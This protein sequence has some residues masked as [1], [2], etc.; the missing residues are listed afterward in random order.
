MLS[1]ILS[2]CTVC[3]HIFNCMVNGEDR[4]CVQMKANLVF[5]LLKL[6]KFYERTNDTLSYEHT[7]Y[8]PHNRRR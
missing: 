1:R 3:Y 8:T 2:L 4:K 6:L 5:L 7:G